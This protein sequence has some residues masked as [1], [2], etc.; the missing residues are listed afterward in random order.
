M[1]KLSDAQQERV[2]RAFSAVNAQPYLNVA[3]LDDL[4]LDGWFHLNDLQL[5]VAMLMTCEQELLTE[6]R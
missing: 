3:D 2:A 6:Q 5:L 1:R 4:C